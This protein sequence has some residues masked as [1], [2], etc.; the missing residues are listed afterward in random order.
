MG[1]SP[2]L[3]G[4]TGWEC[5]EKDGESGLAARD[6]EGLATPTCVGEGVL[7]SE[8]VWHKDTAGT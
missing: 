3:G 1:F 5:V 2:E 4:V 8:T 6:E 7:P